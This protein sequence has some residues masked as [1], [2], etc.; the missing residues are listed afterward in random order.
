MN[1]KAIEAFLSFLRD[2]EQRF[3]MA[4]ADEQEANAETQDVLHSIEIEDHTYNEY[5]Q[6]SKQLK[7]IRKKRREAKTTISECQPVID[8]LDE[9]RAVVK[10]L[11]RLLGDVRKVEK[12]NEGPKLYTPRTGKTKKVVS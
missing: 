8:W 1:S 7:G 3:H 4:D 6:L 10:S 12:Y 2:A 9:N 11:E 5:A